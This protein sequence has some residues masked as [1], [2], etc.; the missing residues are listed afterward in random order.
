MAESYKQLSLQSSLQ[1]NKSRTI[2]KGN[3]KDHRSEYRKN[4]D[5]LK[6]CWFNEKGFYCKYGENCW[7]RHRFNNLICKD[8]V[9][10]K[11]K[12]YHCKYLHDVKAIKLLKE[13]G[14]LEEN[15]SHPPSKMEKDKEKLTNVDSIMAV[16]EKVSDRQNADEVL[17]ENSAIPGDT[18]KPTIINSHIMNNNS[19]VALQEYADL[20]GG[21]TDEDVLSETN[22]ILNLSRSDM[23]VVDFWTNDGG[24]V[25]D[26]LQ[27]IADPG[28]GGLQKVDGNVVDNNNNNTH[29]NDVTESVVNNNISEVLQENAA[30]PGD[31]HKPTIVNSG[32]NNKGEV[33]LQENADIPEDKTD[34]DVPSDTN[35]ILNLVQRGDFELQHQYSKDDFRKIIVPGDGFCLIH[36]VIQSLKALDVQTP[37][38]EDLVK[39]L[40]LGLAEN[41]D[42]YRSHINTTESDPIAEMEEYA[43][44]GKYNSDIGDFLLPLISNHLNIRIVLLM[45]KGEVYMET[46][47]LHSYAPDS[48]AETIFLEFNG[49]HYDSLIPKDLKVDFQEV[50]RKVKA[51]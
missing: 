21:K 22:K 35:K 28:T 4:L 23:E 42:T 51:D 29:N 45:T 15:I 5:K 31:S 12:H 9:N 3:C 7:N 14:S 47:D 44:F 49:Y 37:P 11:C 10:R 46:K 16:K 40:K 18:H 39:D 24:D 26:I 19:E 48:F 25:D 33:V 17:Q 20:P 32:I 43:T 1:S 13:S 2:E 38:K 50:K 36:A 41:F 8:F 6:Y 30:I 27:N 34:E